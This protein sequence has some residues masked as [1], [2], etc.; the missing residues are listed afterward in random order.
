MTDGIVRSASMKLG[1]K[2]I[3]KYV[4]ITYLQISRGNVICV[5]FDGD[6]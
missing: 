4:L 5:G 6:I 2:N 1:V 3:L